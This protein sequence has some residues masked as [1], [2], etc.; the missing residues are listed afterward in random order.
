MVGLKEEINNIRFL[1]MHL[2]NQE[3]KDF[4]EL[5]K[6]DFSVEIICDGNIT[7]NYYDS[8][9][10]YI[11]IMLISGMEKLLFIISIQRIYEIDF[12]KGLVICKKC[13]H[14]SDIKTFA[15]SLLLFDKEK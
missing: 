5:I 14:K 10:R 9:K 11:K 13:K 6:K 7:I 4:L 12:D 3:W 8:G 2:N 1:K 15:N